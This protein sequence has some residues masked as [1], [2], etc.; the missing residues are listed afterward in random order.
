MMR[1]VLLCAMAFAAFAGLLFAADVTGDW[2]G[3]MTFGDSQIP[4]TYTFK[5]EGSKLTG[6]VHGPGGDLPLAEGKVEG[7]KVSFSVM[8][9]M[10]GTPSKFVSEGTL[11]GEEITLQTKGG[12]MDSAPMTLKRA[13]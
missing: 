3:T 11:K 2:S 4:L 1:R 13:K 7:D 6:A 9:D 8:V 12:N 10:N 5:Q